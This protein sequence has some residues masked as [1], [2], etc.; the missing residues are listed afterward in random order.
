MGKLLGLA[1]IMLLLLVSVEA[2]H[3]TV[4]GCPYGCSVNGRCGTEMECKVGLILG[5]VLGICL[6]GAIVYFGC[7]RGKC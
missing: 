7:C 2:R 4:S 6:V 5:I 1:F 3:R